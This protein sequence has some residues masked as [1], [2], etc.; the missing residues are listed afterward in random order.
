MAPGQ[1]AMVNVKREGRNQLVNDQT[2]KLFGYARDELVGQWV[3]LLVP[4]RFRMHHP[5]HRTGFF[6]DPRARSM[7]SG[8]DL[9]GL[10]KDG[11]E[12]PVEISLSPL[13]TEEGTFVSAAIRDVTERKRAAE[14]MAR[15]REA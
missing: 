8:L 3:E 13:E 9:Y 14:T 2:E 11:T 7:G 4:E 10:R 1:E 6:A 5:S 15:A 12:F